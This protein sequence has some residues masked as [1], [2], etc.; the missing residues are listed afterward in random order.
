MNKLYKTGNMTDEEY[1][2]WAIKVWGLR[3]SVEE[4]INLL[5]KGYE[6]NKEVVEVVEKVRKNGYKTLICS[7]NFPARI[8]GLQKRFV[9]LDNFDAYTL[10]Y[11]VGETKPSPNIFNDLVSKSGVNADEIVLADD[12]QANIEGAKYVGIQ[13]FFY[14][15]LDKFLEKLEELGVDLN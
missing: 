11:E 4:V 8:E 13:A 12:N 5:I 3:L 9:F 7:N 10:S 2:T 15:G 14:E 1:W 6:I